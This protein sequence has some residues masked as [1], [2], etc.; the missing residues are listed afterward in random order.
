[1][2]NKSKQTSTEKANYHCFFDGFNAIPS[3]SPSHIVKY[4][5]IEFYRFV[6]VVGLEEAEGRIVR[7]KGAQ[8]EG[9]I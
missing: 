8:G 9:E 1:M 6:L 5:Q 4:V 7:G 2:K 3:S